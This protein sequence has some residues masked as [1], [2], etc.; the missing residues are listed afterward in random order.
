[1]AFTVSTKMLATRLSDR[2][3]I[4]AALRPAVPAARLLKASY[5]VAEGNKMRRAKERGDE[6]EVRRLAIKRRQAMPEDA[7]IN[8]T[9][10]EERSEK[11]WFK[12]MAVIA[13]SYC[14][15][16]RLRAGP[17]LSRCSAN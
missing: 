12:R 2:E 4:Y 15:K 7:F 5:I 10:L 3:A 13:V 11:M 16:V 8:A 6:D 17:R 1:M 14:W 9:E